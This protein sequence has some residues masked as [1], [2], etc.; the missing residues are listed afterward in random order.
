M[1]AVIWHL[2]ML[3]WLVAWLFGL[4][5]IWPRIER[6][7]VSGELA[8]ALLWLLIGALAWIVAFNMGR[9]AVRQPTRSCG[10]DRRAPAGERLIPVS[11]PRPCRNVRLNKVS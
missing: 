8:V 1:M 2:M 9:Q 4:W 11:I 10:A 7:E 3:V 5:W 6:L